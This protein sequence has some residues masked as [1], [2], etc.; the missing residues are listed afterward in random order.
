VTS[1]KGLFAEYEEAFAALDLEKIQDFSPILLS[2][3]ARGAPLRRAR[4]N[5]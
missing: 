4:P 2:Q 5:F 1:S 3:P